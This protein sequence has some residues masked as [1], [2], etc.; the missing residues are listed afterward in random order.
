MLNVPSKHNATM[1][2]EHIT[3]VEENRL[4]AAM[5]IGT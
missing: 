3:D 1:N 5:D 2:L 4:L